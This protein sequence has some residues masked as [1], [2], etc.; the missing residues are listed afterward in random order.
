MSGLI[1]QDLTETIIGV[2][3]QVHFEMG[4]GYLESVYAHSMK[5]A[6]ESAGLKIES[7]VPV[8]VFF[9]GVRV[10]HFRADMIVESKVLLEFKAT[11]KLDS[12]AVPQLLNYLHATPLEVGLILHFGPKA[13]FVRRV[14]S[15]DQKRGRARPQ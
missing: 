15:K 3:Y 14:M 5:L 11:E 1:H 9:R 7:E 10:G 2:F 8:D 12:H 13:E 6:L 4:F